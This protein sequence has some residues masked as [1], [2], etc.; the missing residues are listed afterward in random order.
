MTGGMPLRQ[1]KASFWTCR[2]R[3]CSGRLFARFL[4]DRIGE[5]NVIFVSGTDCYSSPIVESYRKLLRKQGNSTEALRILSRINHESQKEVLGKYDISLNLFAA[6]GLG[7]S[8]DVHAAVSSAL[9]QQWYENG[10]LR[11][12]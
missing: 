11:K 5:E 12:W 3:I 9:M 6:S 2:R 8:K 1:Q 10:H 7:E 4:R